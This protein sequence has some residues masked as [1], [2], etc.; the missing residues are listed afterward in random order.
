MIGVISRHE[1]LAAVEEFFQLFKTPWEI[2]D[3]DKG[4]YEVLIVADSNVPETNAK[5]VVVYGAEKGPLEVAEEIGLE[6]RAPDVH[7]KWG[8]FSIPI[9]GKALT[10]SN[11][12]RPL[13]SC[14]NS[15]Q[16]IGYEIRKGEQR[17]LRIGYDLFGEVSFLLSTGQPAQNALV[18]TLDIH[19]DMLRSWI[20]ETGI[21]LVEIPP[22]PAGYEFIACLTHDVDFISIRQ[23]FIDHSMLG[24]LYRA[25]VG[26][27]ADFF[28]SR[29]SFEKLCENLMAVLTLPFV[30]LGLGRDPWDQFDHHLELEGDAPSTFFFIPFKNNAGEGFTNKRDKY[31]ATKYDVD[32]VAGT[33]EKLLAHG[34]EAGVH[35]IDAWH[36]VEHG[37]KELSRLRCVTGQENTGIRMHWLCQNESTFRLLDQA[38]Y[39]YDSTCGYNDAVGFRAGTTQV[40]KPV[41]VKHL[42]E[43]PLHIQDTALLGPGR[44]HSG[45]DYAAELCD[46]IIRCVSSYKGVLT[47]LWHQRSLGSERLWGDFYKMLIQ[48]LRSKNAW[49]ATAGGVVDWFRIRRLALFAPNGE[50]EFPSSFEDNGKVPRLV[51]RKYHCENNEPAKGLPS[52]PRL[53]QSNYKFTEVAIRPLSS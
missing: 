1:E 7:I 4:H 46:Q 28:R 14:R 38:G 27:A 30:L 32:D 40:F 12:D 9:Y 6:V 10:F 47:L 49:F 11:P 53:G 44:M 8:D 26:S 35:G 19:I 48:K 18:P 50:V 2:Y 16:P 20:I 24:F 43:L 31:R 13:L 5:L 39:Q 3:P 17:I 23:H 41:G 52:A 33:I 22:V 51:L 15:T 36:S 29:F 37:K 34:C 25:T 45:Y 21:P 42:L